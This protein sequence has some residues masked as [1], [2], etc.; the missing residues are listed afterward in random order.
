MS[1]LP[2]I[3]QQLKTTSEKEIKNEFVTILEKL[4]E[5][6]TERGID[7]SLAGGS[8]VGAIRNKG[9]LP[10]DDDADIN[11]TEENYE[12]FRQSLKDNPVPNFVLSD[13]R[14]YKGLDNVG[15]G[16]RDIRGI[17]SISYKLYASVGGFSIDVFNFRPLKSKN[18]EEELFKHRLL[19]G[20]I[21]PTRVYFIPVSKRYYRL[22]YFYY[23][24]SKILPLSVIQKL[25]FNDVYA[26]DGEPHTHYVTNHNIDEPILHK[27]E[28]YDGQELIRVP[29]E[30]LNLPV[31][32]D[33]MFR[34]WERFGHS[35]WRYIPEDANKRSHSGF[36]DNINIPHI[37]YRDDYLRIYNRQ[38][39][40]YKKSKKLRIINFK[41]TVKR[42]D[43]SRDSVGIISL[44]LK[45][46]IQTTIEKENKTIHD[47]I[48][49]KQYLKLLSLFSDYYECQFD[50]KYSELRNFYDIGD[51]L[52]Y[53]AVFPLIF[54]T[55]E[56]FKAK[57]ILNLIKGSR[58]LTDP[59]E[60]VLQIVKYIEDAFWEFDNKNYEKAKEIAENGLK[61]FNEQITLSIIRL[62]TMSILAKN[63]SD[64]EILKKESN[65]LLSIYPENGEIMKAYADGLYGLGEK[66]EA[67]RIYKLSRMITRNGLT[68][69]D[70]NE[71]MK[72]YE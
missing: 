58:K 21:N 40:F 13:T 42:R 45:K 5:T 35:S 16:F 57:K 33:Y 12:K 32:K 26:N 3:R 36:I 50:V 29:F 18:I 39:K 55:G 61:E 71:R 20:L 69:L 48:N 68:I 25:F 30:R 60:K 23:Y 19:C 27:A 2:Q 64:F 24:L 66:D 56:Y 41:N 49:E 15:A 43:A 11:L 17:H 59:L 9:F 37:A 65:R 8:F 1:K 10:W 62:E 31:Q 6:L 63:K 51:D 7:Y 70:I 22:T 4:D 28:I 53:G 14:D 67:L 34:L 46:N 72:R 38:K 52:I 44:V 47:Y 54:F